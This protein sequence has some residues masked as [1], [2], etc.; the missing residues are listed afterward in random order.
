M[1]VEEEDQ[2]DMVN[3]KKITDQ[4]N[5]KREFIPLDHVF[6]YIYHTDRVI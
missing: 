1:V 2:L 3:Q 6:Y 5:Q 4:N